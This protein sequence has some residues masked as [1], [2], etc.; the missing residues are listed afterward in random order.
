MGVLVL[1]KQW[2][3]W[4]NRTGHRIRENILL[5]TENYSGETLTVTGIKW[6]QIFLF[7]AQFISWNKMSELQSKITPARD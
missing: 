4:Q 7:T 2:L 1:A 5:P 3:Q 6:S